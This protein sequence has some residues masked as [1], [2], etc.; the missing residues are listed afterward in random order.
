MRD[1]RGVFGEPAPI[2]AVEDEVRKFDDRGMAEM[3]AAGDDT[4]EQDRGVDRRYFGVEHALAGF[5]IGEVIEESAMVRQLLPQEA[6]RGEEALHEGGGWHVLALIGDTEC[7][8]AEAR[9]GNT[10]GAAGIVG[11]HIGP[12]FDHAGFCVT[13]FPKEKEAGAFQFV[14][15]RIIFWS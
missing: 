1:Q 13:L 7:G 4:A 11:V 8:H 5:G 9:G 10:G 15:K 2:D 12:V 14:E 3:L 6:K